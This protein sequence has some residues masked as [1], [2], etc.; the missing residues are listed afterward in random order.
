MWGTQFTDE[1][2]KRALTGAGVCWV[3]ESTVSLVAP[4]V[5]KSFLSPAL[6]VLLLIL[7]V[8]NLLTVKL[9]VT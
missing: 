4:P 2:D 8:V 9:T 1:L 3:F 6:L 5:L 7:L